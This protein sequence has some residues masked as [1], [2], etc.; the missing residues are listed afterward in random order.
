MKIGT[1][2]ISAIAIL[3]GCSNMALQQ[4]NVIVNIDALKFKQISDSANGIIL[5]V[6]T[7]GEVAQGFIPGS[8]SIDFYDEQFSEKINLMQK[9]KTIFVYCRSGGRSSQAAEILKSNGFNKIYNL[10]GGITSW[11]ENNL[12]IEK[13]GIAEDTGIKQL[14][15]ADFKKMLETDKPVLVDFHTRWCVP[16]KKMAPV[17]DKI[18]EK[19]KENSIVLRIDVDKSKEVA[20]YYNITGIPVFIIFRNGEE[21]WRKNGIITEEKLISELKKEMN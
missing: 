7:P 16:C 14:S 15:L 5:D 13:T 17:V 18:A 10:K 11:E 4:E 3:I 12:P 19:Y 2:I 21:K 1:I 20:K 8:S 9:D 6:R